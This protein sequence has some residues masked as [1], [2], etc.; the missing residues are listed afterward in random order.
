MYRSDIYRTA[1]E[2][3]VNILRTSLE[4]EFWVFLVVGGCWYLLFVGVVVICR[5]LLLWLLLIVVD[6]CCHMSLRVG[7]G[8]YLTDVCC[9]YVSLPVVVVVM[10]RCRLL[11]FVPHVSLPLSLCTVCMQPSSAKHIFHCDP[12]RPI[13]DGNG[14]QPDYEVSPETRR[15]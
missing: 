7:V 9:C 11:S 15:R 3:L 4:G 5:C 8:A 13:H 14:G 10:C 1:I 6:G 2:Q 12:H